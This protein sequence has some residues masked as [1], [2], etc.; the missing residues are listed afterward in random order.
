MPCQHGLK[1]LHPPA[2]ADVA[3]CFLGHH[4]HAERLARETL[5]V[6][7]QMTARGVLEETTTNGTAD[8]LEQVHLLEVARVMRVMLCQYLSRCFVGPRC[9]VE[10]VLFFMPR[11]ALH[12]STHTHTHTHTHIHAEYFL[13]FNDSVD[14]PPQS[15]QATMALLL[16]HTARFTGPRV[17]QIQHSSAS[18]A[19][20]SYKH[21]HTHTHTNTH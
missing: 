11:L 14:A 8:C 9:S 21:T 17:P 7:Q 20:R 1:C 15:S 6:R 10:R 4:A 18:R 13:F 5:A 2:R 12:S 3:S 19:A 16:S